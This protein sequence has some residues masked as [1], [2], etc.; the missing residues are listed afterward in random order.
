VEFRGGMA[1]ATQNLG[2]TDLGEGLGFEGTVSYRFMPHLAA[3]GGWD[4]LRF[5]ADQSFA[6]PD[7]DFEETGYAFG[8]QFDHPFRGETSGAAYR[9]RM[10]ATWNHIEIEDA[11][12]EIFADSGH[13]F[14]W[15]AGTGVIFPFGDTW[16]FTPG[17][18]Y[19]SLARALTVGG[20]S[21]SV[22]LTYLSLE[23]G[24]ARRF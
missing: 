21:T 10:G 5:P 8:L 13:G 1:V 17:L 9:V 15:E 24:F 19:R 12:G 16:R 23:L 20:T 18:R 4:W 7:V 11:D 2:G 3:Y 22:D 6:G 14:G